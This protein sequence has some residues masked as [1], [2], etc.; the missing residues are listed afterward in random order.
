MRDVAD[1]AEWRIAK[2]IEVAMAHARRIPQLEADGRCHYC[3]DDVAHGRLFCNTD[4]RDD[5]QKE[6]EA[7]R[8]AGR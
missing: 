1:R 4:C 7:L 8:R 6:Q 5:Y 3:D 2:D